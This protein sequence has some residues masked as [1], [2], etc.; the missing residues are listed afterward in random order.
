MR[1]LAMAQKTAED[2]VSDAKRDADRLLA[3]ARAKADQLERETQERHRNALGNLDGERERLERKIEE[4][5]SFE[6]EYR[7]RLKSYLEGQLRDLD[8]RAEGV[9]PTAP[10]PLAAAVPAGVGATP[11]GGLNSGA[12]SSAG[13]VVPP[14]AQPPHPPS[15]FSPAPS[16]PSAPAAPSPFLPPTPGSAPPAGGPG[17]PPRQPS[18]GG[19]EVDEGPE[20]PQSNG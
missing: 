10:R 16:T 5:R 18:G 17:G 1:M 8:G 15:P 12:P 13:F 6:R 9:Q 3:D 2:T 7:A 14:A 11:G 20:V 19:F 4:L